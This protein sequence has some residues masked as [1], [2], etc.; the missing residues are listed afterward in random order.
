[1]DASHVVARIESQPYFCGSYT[2]HIR[3]HA[4]LGKNVR[5]N[6]WNY[7]HGKSS[8]NEFKDWFIPATWDVE[9]TEKASVIDLVNQIKLRLAEYSNGH[10]EEPELKAQLVSMLMP[11]RSEA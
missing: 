11:V 3:M 8:L 6:L 4:M 1:M 9:K 5:M 7:L 10:W 2:G